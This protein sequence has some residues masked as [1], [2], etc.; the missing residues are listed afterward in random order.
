MIRFL[1][2]LT[3]ELIRRIRPNYIEGLI[4]IPIEKD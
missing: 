3:E 4:Y 2:A 1:I